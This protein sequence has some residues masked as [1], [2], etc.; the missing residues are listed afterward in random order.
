MS[1][2]GVLSFYLSIVFCPSIFGS[3]SEAHLVYI[4]IENYGFITKGVLMYPEIRCKRTDNRIKLMHH[5]QPQGKESML[6]LL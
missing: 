3:S 1:M 4:G 2:V 5:G 6:L